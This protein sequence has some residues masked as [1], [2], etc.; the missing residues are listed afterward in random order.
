MDTEETGAK[1]AA[2]N[3]VE[4]SHSIDSVALA[5]MIEEVRSGDPFATSGSYNRTHN[6][7]N[8]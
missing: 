2:D 5:R 3:P 8:R 4:L 7:H 6:R 1:A